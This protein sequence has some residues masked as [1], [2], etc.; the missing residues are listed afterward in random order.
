[1]SEVLQH[2]PAVEG[3]LESELEMARNSTSL[4][5]TSP[6]KSKRP[7]VTTSSRCMRWPLP[8]ERGFPYTAIR[9]QNRFMF[10]P[11]RSS[12][13]IFTVETK[14]GSLVSLAI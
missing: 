4:E 5:F 1:M 3:V 12:F 9:Q 13:I 11:A 8:R 7:P 14:P 2:I 6:G 10:W